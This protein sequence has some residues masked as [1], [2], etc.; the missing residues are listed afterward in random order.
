MT[1]FQ[2]ITARTIVT[3]AD[4]QPEAFACR[5]EWIVGSGTLAELRARFPG[6]A[7]HDFGVAT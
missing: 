7:V 5:G 3:F 2:I 6:A 1:D 4:D